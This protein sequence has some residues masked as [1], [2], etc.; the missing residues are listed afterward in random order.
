MTPTWQLQIKRNELTTTRI[1]EGHVGDSNA[2]E[3]G[4]GPAQPP[5]SEGEVDFK[6]DT[7]AM[8]ANNI[9]YAV[10]G[11]AMA[12]WNFFPVDQEWGVVPVW[13][14]ADV[15]DS[16]HPSLAIGDR[17]YGYWPCGSH[18]RVQPTKATPRGFVDG[19]GHRTQLPAVYNSYAKTETD[20]QYD[21]E[22]EA[23]QS[24]LRPL[25]TTSFFIDDY[26]GEIEFSGAEQVLIASASSKT[27]FALAY[28]LH[29]RGTPAIGLTSER[30]V[31]F[32]ESLGW[33]DDVLTY[34][35]VADAAC[36]ALTVPSVYVDMSGNAELRAN[37]HN[38]CRDLRFDLMV[39]A[40]HW[41]S[42]GADTTLPG[43]TPELFFA[44]TQIA[45]RSKEWGSEGLATRT[46]EVWNPFMA[47]LPDLL[48]VEVV[49]GA[50]ACAAAYL[51]ALE[52]SAKPETGIVVK[53]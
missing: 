33:Y 21:P 29:R 19:T 48:D 7:F 31:A 26:L 35:Q 41:D 16:R 5:L 53:A 28:C 27:A 9:T 13:G 2:N 25:F 3:S 18:L 6:I 34:E 49:D 24:L 30:N 10:F 50:Q 1:A 12:Y 8:T 43:P 45:R 36:P 22:T 17:Y 23:L 46:A 14:F 51:A 15:V 37:I 39:G 20:P 42:T 52:G 40:T 38:F 11:D 44:P 4:T 47:E 32:V